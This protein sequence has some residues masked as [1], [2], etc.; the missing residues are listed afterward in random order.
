MK[1][2]RTSKQRI[3][4]M[5]MAEKKSLKKSAGDLADCE[6]ITN[7]RYMAICRAIKSSGY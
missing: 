7:E 3:K 6:A 1:L 5:T 2:S 4:R